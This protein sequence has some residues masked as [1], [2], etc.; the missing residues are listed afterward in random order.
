MSGYNRPTYHG[1]PPARRSVSPQRRGQPAPT[2]TAPYRTERVECRPDLAASLGAW[3]GIAIHEM[4]HGLP[5][6]LVFGGIGINRGGIPI[7]TPVG[8]IWLPW[9]AY[10]EIFAATF[11]GGGLTAITFPWWIWFVSIVAPYPIH[12]I[13]RLLFRGRPGS[14]FLAGFLAVMCFE[15]PQAGLPDLVAILP[16]IYMAVVLLLAR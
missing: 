10:R 13:F 6:I 5:W 7:P 3:L 12:L 4:L 1:N 11:G 9:V 14:G 15:M 16:A 2:R 8:G